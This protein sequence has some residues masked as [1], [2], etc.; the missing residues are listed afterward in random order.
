MDCV[1]LTNNHDCTVKNRKSSKTKD[2][3]EPDE[4]DD[5]AGVIINAGKSISWR[6]MILIWITFLVI[7]SES[8][9]TQFL[10]HMPDAVDRDGVMTMSGTI[11]ASIVMMVG[12]I[13]I[14]MIYR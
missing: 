5:F 7:H 1:P 12:V 9:V 8:F 10:S 14:D 6:E 13:I 4:H 3:D 11:Y 2:P